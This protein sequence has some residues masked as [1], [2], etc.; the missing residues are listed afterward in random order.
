M[1]S[2]KDF[3]SIEGPRLIL[4]PLKSSDLRDTAQALVSPTTWF[5]MT[6]NIQTISDFENYFRPILQKQEAGESLSL[7]ARLKSTSK[8]VGMSTFQYPSVQ[9]T[10]VE[11]GFTWLSD[12]W[13]RTFVNSE[14]KYLM[15]AHAFEVMKT[16]RV[17]FSIHPKNTKSNEAIKR[18]GAQFE[19]TLRK[20]RYLP[21]SDDG[22]R[23]IYSIIDDE[24]P[25]VKSQLVKKLSSPTQG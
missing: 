3:T 23:N 21:G 9:F 11:I 14:M 20:W 19:G 16:L 8:I 2:F 25:A 13:Q 5:S 4:R 17:E 10:K 12:S 18:I 7:L 22:N 24:W 15:L 6:R 1:Y